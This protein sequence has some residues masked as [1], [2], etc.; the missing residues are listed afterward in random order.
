MK[1][2]IYHIIILLFIVSIGHAQEDQLFIVTDTTFMSIG[3]HRQLDIELLTSKDIP[4][5]KEWINNLLD[6]TLY[7]GRDT[8]INKAAEDFEIFSSTDWDTRPQA[9]GRFLSKIA[10]EYTAWKDGL[11]LIPGVQLAV[12]NK[13]LS[14]DPVQLKVY[15]PIDTSMQ[16]LAPIKDIFTTDFDFSDI[17]RRMGI[18]WFIKL[19]LFSALLVAI[20]SLFKKSS[21]RTNDIFNIPFSTY[22]DYHLSQLKGKLSSFSQKEIY[23]SVVSLLK[24]AL[25]KKYKFGALGY[26]TS[27]LD[28]K[29]N[30]MTV[31]DRNKIMGLLKDADAVKYARTNQ[32]Q[33]QINQDVDTLATVISSLRGQDQSIDVKALDLKEM[34]PKFYE[35]KR[36]EQFDFNEGTNRLFAGLIDTGIILLVAGL[37]LFPFGFTDYISFFINNQWSIFLMATVITLM[38]LIVIYFTMGHFLRGMTIGKKIMNVEVVDIDGG[39]MSFIKSLLRTILGLIGALFLCAGLITLFFDDRRQGIHDKILKTFVVN[40]V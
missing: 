3:E 14:V 33:G 10:Y 36:I 39:Q 29:L 31:P 22:A 21:A 20:V 18:F 30:T 35:Q 2:R 24:S 37:V 4:L 1:S 25:E 19:L 38:V 16:G 17:K 12:N 13:L 34:D 23:T 9:D 6:S 32:E 15:T 7:L 28:R 8:S 40:R 11:Y 5:E 27:M 26:T